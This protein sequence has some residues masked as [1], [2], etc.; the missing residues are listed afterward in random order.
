MPPLRQQQT[1]KNT[2]PAVAHDCDLRGLPFP[3]RTGL[4]GVS[5]HVNELVALSA[6]SSSL[7]SKVRLLASNYIVLQQVMV[8]NQFAGCALSR[9]C[10]TAP[11]ACYSIFYV[12]MPMYF[13]Q[14]RQSRERHTMEDPGSHWCL[15][16]W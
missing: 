16:R 2:V 5:S 13:A 3:V 11:H 7:M 14:Q 4:S 1:F 8:L 9:H 15:S 6:S 10:N 12:A